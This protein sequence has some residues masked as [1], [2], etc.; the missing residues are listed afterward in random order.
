MK[1]ESLETLQTIVGSEIMSFTY[2][3][4]VGIKFNR[5]L[6]QYVVVS[7]GK[8]VDVLDTDAKVETIAAELFADYKTGR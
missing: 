6:R 1:K 3:N 2:S 8:Q 7:E 5:A 4:I